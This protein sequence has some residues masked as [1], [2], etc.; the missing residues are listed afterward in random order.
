MAV[1]T[2]SKLFKEEGNKEKITYF[3]KKA[4]NKA[5]R[6]IIKRV[7]KDK[8]GAS[9]LSVIVYDNLLSYALVGDVML[10]IF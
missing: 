3:F 7:E 1:K 5:S 10:A 4:F 6:E 2:I 8:G 9:V